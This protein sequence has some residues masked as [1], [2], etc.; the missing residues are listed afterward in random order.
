MKKRTTDLRPRLSHHRADPAQQIS[1]RNAVPVFWVALLLIAALAGGCAIYSGVQY[2]L[3]IL[4]ND[5]ETEIYESS[6]PG[7][8]QRLW[9]CS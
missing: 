4:D 3:G 5:T 6:H 8:D 1:E 9:H 2:V 7:R